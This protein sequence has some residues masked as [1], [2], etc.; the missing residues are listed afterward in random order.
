[1]YWFSLKYV[2]LHSSVFQKFIINFTSFK[3]HFGNM[4]NRFLAYS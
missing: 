3:E 4:L 2:L 1:M